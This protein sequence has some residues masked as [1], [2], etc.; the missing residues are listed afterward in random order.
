VVAAGLRRVIAIHTST[1][2]G[3]AC[4]LTP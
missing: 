1:T 4:H 3:V 2:I